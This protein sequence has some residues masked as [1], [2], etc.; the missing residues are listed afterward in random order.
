MKKP[1]GNSS[2][3]KRVLWE[4]RQKYNVDKPAAATRRTARV[5]TAPSTPPPPPP[6]REMTTRP[7]RRPRRHWGRRLVLGILLLVA[8]SGGIFGYKILAAG[9]KIS[10]TDRSLLGQLTD[11]LF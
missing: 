1:L 11:L 3:E 8:L 9:N 2:A 10:T 6:P 5:P 7:R 4:V